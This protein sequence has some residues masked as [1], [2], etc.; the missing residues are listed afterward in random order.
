VDDLVTKGTDEPYR[1]FT[2]RAEFRL[3]LR[4]DN[5]LQR[6]GP[7][8]ASRG[9]LTD[10]QRGVMEERLELADRVGDWL[11]STNA[12]PGRI[13]PS[14]EEIGSSPLAE[15]TRLAI[16]LRRPG[17]TGD[18]L[19]RTSDGAPAGE[20]VELEEVVA[21]VEMEL[22]YAGYLERERVRA[23][24]LRRNADF[25]IPVDLEWSEL[26]SLSYEARQKLGRVRPHT[27]AQAA[28]VPGVSPSDLQNLVMEVRKR[29]GSAAPG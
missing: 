14:L 10:D 13:N 29:R 24:S 16:L 28:R 26:A 8:A 15:P 3:T 5:A 18:L 22:K 4:Q 21:A 1:L 9:L 19:L 7:L 6:V 27:L 17:V 23:D 11:R 20:P 25:A 2:S 12:D